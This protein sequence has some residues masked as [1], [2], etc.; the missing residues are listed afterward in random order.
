MY[1]LTMDALLKNGFS[2]KM[3]NYF[4]RLIENERKSGLWDI[5]E[6]EKIHTKGFLAESV[7]SYPLWKEK[8]EQYLSDYDYYRIWPLN[9][10]ERVW[11]NDKLTLKYILSGTQFDKYM[12]RYYYYKSN[13]GLEALVDCPENCRKGNVQDLIDLLI[14]EGKIACKPCNGSLSAGFFQLSYKDENIYINGEKQ[15]IE[16]LNDFIEDHPNYIYTEFFYPSTDMAKIFP[17]IHTIRVLTIKDKEEMSRIAGAYLRFGTNESGYANYMTVT[18]EMKFVYDVEINTNTGEYDAGKAVYM[19]HIE[20]MPYHPDTNVLVK[21]I[22]SNWKEAQEMVLGIA[23]HLALVEYMGFDICFTN[24]GVK[25]MEINSHSGIKHI[26]MR[27]PLLEEE[28]TRN[29]FERKIEEVN[30]LTESERQ[31]RNN[32]VR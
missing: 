27:K 14:D 6:L 5:N 31:K 10:W 30:N 20:D 9:N 15:T 18:P 26:Q 2:I 7:A 12:P 3:A 4:L 32:L 19:D 17:L 21:G 16:Q 13:E 29:Y 22:I 28:W 8:P 1:E 25:I 23:Q 11:I 24:K